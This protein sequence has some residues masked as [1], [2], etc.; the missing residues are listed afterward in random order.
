MPEISDQEYNRLKQA[1]EELTTL[2]KIANSINL[3]MTVDQISSNIV[4]HCRKRVKAGQGVIF[5]LDDEEK[6]EDRFKT[7]VRDMAPKKNQLPFHLNNSL[8][9]W[10]LKNKDILIS[11]TPNSD[12]RL[13]GVDFDKLGMDSLI[14]APL[15]SR[16]GLI[17]ILVLYN[18]TGGNGFEELDKRFLGIVGTQVTKVIED[19]RLIDK[20]RKLNSIEKEIKVAKTIQEGFLP[21]NNIV[22]DQ[23]EIYGFNIP[24]KEVGGDYYDMIP[25]DD[26][27]VFVSLGDISGKGMPAALLTGNAQAVLRSQIHQSRDINLPELADCLNNLIY[28]FTSSEQ[29]IT[30]LFGIFNKAENKLSYINAGHLPPTIVRNNGT[31][32]SHDLANLV[33]GVVP[34]APFNTYELFLEKGESAYIFTDGITEAMN[35]NDEQFGDD[36]FNEIL[37]K[38][39]GKKPEHVC[40]EIRR[41]IIRFRGKA[42]QS[43]DIT[44]LTIKNG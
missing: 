9:G 39:I 38:N 2:N 14:A 8:L 25:L 40:S 15:L 16:R 27:R 23:F 34:D 17:G 42:E 21:K 35:E 10:M 1:V 6:V 12:D 5:L 37:I 3:T 26:N 36:R 24:A 19:A 28:Q 18:K 22:N 43:D 41:E 31:I 13:R 11:N 30:A 20:E 29:Y 32:E 44:V 4:E 33:I 7:F